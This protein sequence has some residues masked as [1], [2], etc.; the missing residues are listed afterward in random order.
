M[1]VLLQTK[2]LLSNSVLFAASAPLQPTTSV[3]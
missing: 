2:T 3:D 1:D